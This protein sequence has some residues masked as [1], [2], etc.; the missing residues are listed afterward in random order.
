VSSKTAT[1]NDGRPPAVPARV[2]RGLRNRSPAR[3]TDRTLG[4]S[5]W[6]FWGFAYEIRLEGIHEAI[7][8][9]LATS[10]LVLGLG[11]C[12]SAP[13]ETEQFDDACQDW[14]AKHYPKVEVGPGEDVMES[15]F[16]PDF[17]GGGYPVLSGA[18]TL[19]LPIMGADQLICTGH[20]TDDGPPRVADAM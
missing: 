14:I 15:P 1:A 19:P 11:A 17:W 12:S 2:H 13:S 8:S 16:N 18:E 7:S 10:A 5:P 6:H 9:T 4:E 3:T 20:K